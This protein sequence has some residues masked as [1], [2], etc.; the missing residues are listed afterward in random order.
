MDDLVQA[1]LVT[2]ADA[3]ELVDLLEAGSQDEADQKVLDLAKKAIGNPDYNFSVEVYNKVGELTRD[4]HDAI[5]D[6]ASDERIKTIA[7][8]EIP[9]ASERLKNIISMTDQAANRTLDAVD[10]CAPLAT[11][12]MELIANLLPAWKSL[13]HGKIDRFDFV[14]LCHKIDDLI[15][16]TQINATRLSSQLNEIVLAQDYQDLTGQMIQRVI[17]LVTEVEDKLVNFLVVCSPNRKTGV[18]P[19]Q[20]K[21]EHGSLKAEGPSLA[22]ERDSGEA[23]SSQ[24]DVDDLLASLGF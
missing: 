15:S 17:K 20:E 14:T 23:A 16:Q 11:T 8:F 6:F 7:D 18:R 2:L 21:T 22:R 5:S 9:D 19:P 10:A 24:G 12:L 13:M 4:L 3:V 1:P